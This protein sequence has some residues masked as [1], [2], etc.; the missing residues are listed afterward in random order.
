MGSNMESLDSQ[1]RV[2]VVRHDE[3]QVRLSDLDSVRSDLIPS[4]SFL[5]ISIFLSGEN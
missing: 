4:I 1:R 2:Y 5:S 3:T